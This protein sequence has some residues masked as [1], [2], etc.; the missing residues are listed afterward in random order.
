MISALPQL[1]SAGGTAVRRDV[2][3]GRV[4][5]EAPTRVLRA[6]GRSV[7]TAIWPGVRTLASTEFIASIDDPDAAARRVA[8]LDS[9]A[10]GRFELGT[11][12]WQRT[13]FVAEV[14]AGRW[15]GIV[16]MYAATGR[17]LCWYVNFERPPAWRA[18]GWDTMDLA[19]DLVVEP[20][21]RWR[22][23]DEDEYAHCRRLGLVTDAEHAE[24]GRAREQAVE[25]VERRVGVFAED[26]DALWLP[27]PAWPLPALR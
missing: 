17:L 15:F 21:G 16:R 9:L 2:F 22:W 18:D 5:T 20:D 3:G 23:K 19:L 14:V 1:L 4:W 13:A 27:D 7:T 11:W 24:V 25:Q 26:P 10:E 8:S 6:D 12:V